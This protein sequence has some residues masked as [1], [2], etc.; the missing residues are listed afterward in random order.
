MFSFEST[1]RPTVKSQLKRALAIGMSS[2]IGTYTVQTVFHFTWNL[3]ILSGR[4]SN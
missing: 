1:D 2:D 4:K 3:E